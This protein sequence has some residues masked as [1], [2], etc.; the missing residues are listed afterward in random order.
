MT[1]PAAEELANTFERYVAARISWE[2]LRNPEATQAL[3]EAR[4][5]LVRV[6]QRI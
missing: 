2:R 4:D 1:G 6:L 3:Q 5:G